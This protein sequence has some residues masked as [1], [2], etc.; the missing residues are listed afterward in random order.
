[1]ELHGELVF[2]D[3]DESVF[4]VSPRLTFQP[5]RDKSIALGIGLTV[6]VLKT[7]CAG[8]KHCPPGLRPLPIMTR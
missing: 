3:A 1:M 4:S 5:F 2:G 6:P 7:A 8:E